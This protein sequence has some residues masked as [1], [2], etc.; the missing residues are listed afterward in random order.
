M[1]ATKAY[2]RSD[3]TGFIALNA[4]RLKVAAR[5]HNKEN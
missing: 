5:V 3:A 2:N 1:N 4:P